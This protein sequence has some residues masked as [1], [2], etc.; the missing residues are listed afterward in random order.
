MTV[1]ESKLS[2]V[3]RIALLPPEEQEAIFADFTEADHASFQNDW[4]AWA[5]PD[6]II[7]DEPYY[8]VHLLL[9][10]RGWGKTR[11]ASEWIRQQ[12]KN[13]PGC[14]IAV[15][16]RTAKDVRDVMVLGESG[17]I[18]VCP[19]EEKPLWRPSENRLV[20]QQYNDSQVFLYSAEAPEAPRGSQFHYYLLDEWASHPPF[21][22]N[23]GL[24]AAENV[25]LATRLGDKPY[26]V[27]TTTP[28]RVKHLQDMIKRAEE[29]GDVRIVHGH[30]TENTA[31][32]S[33]YINEIV[34]KYA[35][36]RL[37]EQELAGMML[38]ADLDGVLWRQEDIDP[39]RDKTPDRAPA[40]A[41]LRVV[42]VD[43][44]VAENPK[45]LCG[46]VVAGATKSRELHKRH[47]YIL[48]DASLKASP[49][50]WAKK[51]VEVYKKWNAAAVVVEMNQ[52]QHLV[53]MAIHAVDPTVRII[54]VNASRGKKLRAEPVTVPYQQG[55]V[56]HWVEASLFELETQ[57]TQWEPGNS[58]YS[59]DRVDALVHALTALL[60]DQP[61]G[62]FSGP[63]TVSRTRNRRLPTGGK[64]TGRTWRSGT[65]K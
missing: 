27:I 9:T 7:P 21:S 37:A 55:R 24:T 34:G 48:E 39:Y 59:P 17:I 15:V 57:M 1:D 60:I 38:S 41:Q 35:G 14:R 32:S 29:K 6:Q 5:R 54:G 26:G 56:H 43:P 4:S 63:I 23:E 8:P 18:A 19:E 52:G 61:K 47:A 64:G 45:D 36:T 53:K 62:L 30:T 3:Q 20:W 2:L 16:G 50:V 11:A 10:G 49:E 28:R 13:H 46:I 58:K 40:G 12:V 51:V 25:M 33:T 42:G 31:L 22:G 65:S 44:S